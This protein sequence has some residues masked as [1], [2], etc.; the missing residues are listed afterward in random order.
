MHGGP[1]SCEPQDDENPLAGGRFQVDSYLQYH[2]EKLAS[3]FDAASYVI[4]TASM[5]SHDVG[6]DRGGVSAA[7]RRVEA[8]VV[9]AGVDSDRLY[10]L[11][12]Q[13]ALAHQLGVP[14][15][16]ATVIRSPYG[17]DG[18]LIEFPQVGRI[19]AE[20]LDRVEASPRTSDR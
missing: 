19:V 5:N 1:R 7:L 4:L 6:R 18:F 13:H 12:E 2:G 3:R 14:G 17:H 10:P 11:E 15:E 9:V 20:L 16:R 8:D